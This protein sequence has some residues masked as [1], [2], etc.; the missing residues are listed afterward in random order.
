[1]RRAR[2][3]FISSSFLERYVRYQTEQIFTL[4]TVGLEDFASACLRRLGSVGTYN[5][6]VIELDGARKLAAA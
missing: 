3:R 1:M 2:G 4:A 5:R 6:I